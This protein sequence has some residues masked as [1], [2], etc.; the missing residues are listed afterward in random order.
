VTDDRAP[1][2]GGTDAAAIACSHLGIA[3]FRSAWSVWAERF[4]PD[5][6]PA[7]DPGMQHILDLGNELEPYVLRR[8][9]AH[10][11]GLPT[12]EQGGYLEVQP[13]MKI[14]APEP[15]AWIRGQLDGTVRAGRDVVG[16]V[17][18]KTSRQRRHWFDYDAEDQRL[19][20]CP[21]GYE[22]Q[23]RWY[24]GL[25]R[26]AGMPVRWADLAALDL[27][28]MD[29]YVRRI[30]HEEARWGGILAIVLPW[31]ERHILGGEQPPDD[32]SDACQ[33]WHLYC[34][35]RVLET[36]EATDEQ[37]ERISDWVEADRAA[38]AATKAA[39]IARAAVLADLTASTTERL[40]IGD[41][42]GP[43]VQRQRAGRSSWCARH[44]R[45][46]EE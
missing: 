27:L 43:Y 9:A 21:A 13:G 26:L 20:S 22:I 37:A 41:H 23:V 3:Y 6:I 31:W 46:P 24:M 38:K 8:Y 42:A 7:P 39:D 30:A 25:A 16:I 36:A 15:R 12:T 40:Y 11:A 28:S 14:H 29:L 5:A 35:P 32:H 19:D 18:A 33:R 44:Y 1:Y 2:C 4:A 34:R 10:L 17:D 45:F